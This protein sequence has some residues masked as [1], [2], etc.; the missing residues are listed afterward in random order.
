MGEYSDFFLFEDGYLALDHGDQTSP[1][2]WET[3][4]L[5]SFM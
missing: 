3:Y 4:S 5:L 2:Q 1:K